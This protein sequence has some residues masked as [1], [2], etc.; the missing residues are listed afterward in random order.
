MDIHINCTFNCI[1]PPQSAT[2]SHICYSA[3]FVQLCTCLSFMS[4]MLFYST[5]VISRCSPCSDL[6]SWRLQQASIL[7][8]HW[9]KWGH[10]RSTRRT[11]SAPESGFTTCTYVY[12]HT[13][14]SS[15]LICPVALEGGGCLLNHRESGGQWPHMGRL[16][17][18]SLSPEIW[19]P[20]RFTQTLRGA[21]LTHSPIRHDG[22]FVGPHAL[23]THLQLADAPSAS[24]SERNN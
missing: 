7:S 17:V 9:N 8:C 18:M 19:F 12:M 21:N 2:T 10:S 20:F 3:Q 4:Y 23:F 11:R 13:S 6:G 5:T 14:P 24:P 1:I 22:H 15:E 16:F